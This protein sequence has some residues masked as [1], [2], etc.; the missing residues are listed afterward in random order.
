ME[1]KLSVAMATYNGER[2]LRGQLESLARQ[3]RL[4]DELVVCDDGSTDSTVHVVEEFG[5]TAPFP[6]RVYRNDRRLGFADN[7]LAAA[8]RCEGDLI[9][10]CDQDDI[11][12]EHKLKRCIVVFADPSVMLAMHSANVVDEHL[13][14]T[15]LHFPQIRNDRVADALAVDPW[16]EASG[17]A[18]VF[19]RK[20][21]L[22]LAAER[23]SASIAFD[24]PMVHDRWVWFLAGVFGRIALIAESLV[25]Y[26]RHQNTATSPLAQ[27]GVGNVCQSLHAGANQYTAQAALAAER[28]DFLQCASAHLPA[29]AAERAAVGARYYRALEQRHAMRASLY[30]DSRFTRRLATLGRLLTAGAYASRTKGGFG[31]RSLAKDATIGLMAAS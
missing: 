19:R 28:A 4:P 3:D 17:F 29:P 15:G 14:S 27:T 18:M 31:A 6:V 10:F 21:P 5:A 8:A 9:A 30:A 26:R 24:A 2:F 13:G 25:L 7:F 20:L 12:L 1:L 23:P 16:G 22:V 11:W